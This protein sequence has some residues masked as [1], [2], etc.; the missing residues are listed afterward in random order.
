M[1]ILDVWTPSKVNSDALQEILGFKDVEKL[2]ECMQCGT[3]SASC[4]VAVLA[5]FTPRQ[6]IQLLNLGLVDR[7]VVS[8]MAFLCTNCYA[9]SARC[10]RDIPVADVM[11]GLRNMAF[12]RGL[13][14]AKNYEY[15]KGFSDIILKRGRIY[16]PELVLRFGMRADPRALTSQANAIIAL[17][18]KGKIPI[19]PPRGGGNLNAIR[20]RMARGGQR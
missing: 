12:S 14:P 9:C 3:C 5:D 7:A 8:R 17:L 19:I 10:P 18:L 1:A 20:K 13:M 4:P 11:T 6:I 16:E 15:Y 2:Q